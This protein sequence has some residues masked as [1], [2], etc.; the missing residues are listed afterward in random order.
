VQ[1][2][3]EALG[4]TGH[5][6][7][8]QWYRGTAPDTAIPVGTNSGF[9]T[10]NPSVTTSYWVR[11]ANDCP[12]GATASVTA[13][14]TICNAPAVSLPANRTI[15]R[16]TSTTL[17]ATASG[18]AVL[19]YQWYTVV[20]TTPSQINGATSSSLIV[21][22]TQTTRYRVVVTND[23]GSDSDDMIVNVVDPPTTPSSI[24]ASYDA[25]SG[26]NVV[27]WTGSTSEVGIDHYLVERMP[28][29]LTFSST[30]TTF[31]DGIALLAGHTYIYRILAVDS[32]N[33]S[34][35]P[36]EPDLTT[37]IAFSDD[38]LVGGVS[39]IRGVHVSELRQAIDAV[40]AAAGLAPAWSDYSPLTGA[41]FAATFTELRNRLN[42]ARVNLLLPEISFSAIVANGEPIQ[43]GTVTELRN[44][45]Q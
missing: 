6:I 29:A 4:E 21:S 24:S 5:A 39:L 36:S 28:D 32:Q 43:A 37:R 38:P 41:V 13:T 23:C 27:S 18:S 22:P 42:E 19:E 34:S 26:K 8:Y 17:I 30:G 16:T 7:N 44:G 33:V 11:A 40:R 25:S 12:N 35:D 15:T 14:V 9:L 20:G 3:A 45:V 2:E 1:L 10:V 31:Q